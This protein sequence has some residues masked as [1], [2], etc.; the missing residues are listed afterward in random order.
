MCHYTVCITSSALK[1][2]HEAPQA[3]DFDS[4]RV[5]PEGTQV[6][7]KS[8]GGATFD[9]L[10]S[11]RSLLVTRYLACSCVFDWSINLDGTVWTFPFFFCVKMVG[12]STAQL[13]RL[14]VEW[15]LID[16]SKRFVLL[17]AYFFGLLFLLFLCFL[18]LN[19]LQTKMTFK[20]ERQINFLK[21][22]IVSR[23]VVG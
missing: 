4:A 2:V 3:W 7:P 6:P 17:M 20:T 10:V 13:S 19:S 1:L 9:E 12:W 22:H 11:I 16:Q 23:L 21:Y 5:S 15:K 14:E 8:S 18:K